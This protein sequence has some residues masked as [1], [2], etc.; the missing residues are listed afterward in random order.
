[1]RTISPIEQEVNQ[2]R[3]QVY[4]K[5]KDMSPAQLTGA[6][7]RLREGQDINVPSICWTGSQRTTSDFRSRYAAGGR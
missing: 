6:T 7:G 2:I 3:L 4:E 1:M 5:T